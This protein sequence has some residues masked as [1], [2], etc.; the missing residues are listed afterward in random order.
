MTRQELQWLYNL[1]T[2]VNTV[3][4]VGSWKGRSTTALLAGGA[5]VWAVDTWKGSDNELE[6]THKE[7]TECNLL[8][9]FKI[10]M[11][12]EEMSYPD[13][14]VFVEMDSVKAAG[15]CG[16]AP[17]MPETVEAVFIDGNHTAEAVEADVR[18]WLPK[19]TRFLCGHDFNFPS[20]REGLSKALGEDMRRVQQGPGAIWFIDLSI[21]RDDRELLA[22]C[23]PGTGFSRAWLAQ[24]NEL[25]MHLAKKFRLLLF[26]AESN[27]IYQVRNVI[28]EAMLKAPE[29]P[30]RVLWIDSDNLVC[31][32][33]FENLY[34]TISE[35]DTVDA[36]GAWY[37]FFGPNGTLIAAGTGQDL[38]PTEEMIHE[39][40]EQKG[41]LQVGY[42]GFGFLL[43]K[44]E[45]IEALGVDAFIPCHKVGR[46][47]TDDGGFC[48]R[49][50]EKGYKFFLHPGVFAPHLKLGE[51]AAIKPIVRDK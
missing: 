7:A 35:N 8:E 37:R 47:S 40:A 50:V 29:K 28:V 22:V 17:F 42:I 5:R 6:T 16:V 25:Y 15:L 34:T 36:V 41:L 12:T 43:M 24:W 23:M 14:L 45:V 2:N 3:A 21:P 26:Y 39:L 9:V 32:D 49:A 18:A 44:F 19:V 11:L 33:G 31:V 4:E 13:N 46:F 51:V 1:S 38:R 20:V 30:K 10:N 27:N 48:D